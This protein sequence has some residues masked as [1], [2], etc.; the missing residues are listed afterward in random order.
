MRANRGRSCRL[1]QHAAFDAGFAGSTAADAGPAAVRLRTER[2]G[3]A[4]LTHI[5]PAERAQ[6]LDGTDSA[7]ARWMADSFDTNR[8]SARRTSR[9]RAAHSGRDSVTATK[10]S[11]SL[12]RDLAAADG[13]SLEDSA[14]RIAIALRAGICPSDRAFDKH[15]PYDLRVVSTQYW[16]PIAVAVRAAEW[17]DRLDVRAVVDIGSGAGKFCVAAALATRCRFTGLEQRPRLASAARALALM[18]EVDDRV[19]FV[20]GALGATQIPVPDAYYLYNPF[21][22][23]L[24]GVDERLDDA[25]E[26]GPDRYARDLAAAQ[27][28]LE[29][30]PAGTWVLTYNGLGGE[31]PPGYRPH[32][33]DRELPNEL[34]LWK[35]DRT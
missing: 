25:V 20:T 11:I 26:L 6:D 32:W 18:F 28:L 14:R 16:T 27:E 21:G 23:N 19:D 13:P 9:A 7:S 15:L 35:K 8:S 30:A 5:A 22:E 1:P 3:S 33:L 17:F 2:R 31:L 4:A 34:C 24:F 29:S 12:A 10:R